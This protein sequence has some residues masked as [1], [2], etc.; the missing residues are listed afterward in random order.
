[1]RPKVR[2]LRVEETLALGDRRLLAI[3]E[4]NEEELLIGVTPQQ[5]TLLESREKVRR[6]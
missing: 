1:V 3:V 5:I 4:W 2:A 6:P